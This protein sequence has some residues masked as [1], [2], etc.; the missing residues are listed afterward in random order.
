MRQKK[1]T[2]CITF[3]IGLGIHGL[4]AQESINTAGGDANGSGGSM[5]YSI[6][7]IFIESQSGGADGS[8][9]QGVQQPIEWLTLG[10][11]EDL[12]L[13]AS[14]KVFPNPTTDKIQLRLELEDINNLSYQIYDINGKFLQ[15]EEILQFTT[16][17]QLSQ[18]PTSVYFLKIIR[19][20]NLLKTFRILKN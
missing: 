14:A 6:G 15:S 12:L 2:L 7:Q 16:E 3:L 11:E 4:K 19:N 10:L 13:I 20:N 5:S 8:V 9:S 1:L 17:I 18:L